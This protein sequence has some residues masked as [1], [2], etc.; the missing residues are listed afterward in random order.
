MRSTVAKEMSQTE[1]RKLTSY[2]AV[3]ELFPVGPGF[4]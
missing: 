2:Y 1:S 4:R 3:V